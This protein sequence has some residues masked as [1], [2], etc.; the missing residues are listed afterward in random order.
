VEQIPREVRPQIDP[1][2]GSAFALEL[3]QLDAEAER[4][5]ASGPDGE[6]RALELYK[7]AV[8]FHFDAKRYDE[9]LAAIDKTLKIKPQAY[10]LATKGEILRQLGGE[11]RLNEAVAALEEAIRLEPDNG[12]AHVVYGETLRMLNRL[13]DAAAELKRAVEIDSTIG[14]WHSRLAE[15]LV[16]LNRLP[17]ALD[18]LND[19]L[20]YN[21]EN[22]AALRRR[23]DVLRAMGRTAEALV[24]FDRALQLAPNHAW[25]L[26][27]KGEALRAGGKLSDA[28]EALQQAIQ[29]EP[30]GYPWAETS[31]GY[32]R[33]NQNRDA[34]ALRWF[35]QA[36]QGDSNSAWALE[37]MVRALLQLDQIEKCL[38]TSRRLLEFDGSAAF[39]RGIIGVLM[40]QIEEYAR[41]VEALELST[42]ADAK[43]SWSHN[44]LANCYIWLAR[45]RAPTE[46]EE[47]LDK[48]IAEATVA[49]ELEPSD[50]SWRVTLAEALFKRSRTD[51]AAAE[52]R[53]AHVIGLSG[54]SIDYYAASDAGWAAYRLALL[55]P[56]ESTSFLSQAEQS[57]VDALTVKTARPDSSDAVSVKFNLA[58]VMLCSGRFALALREFNRA[59]SL[60]A[61][62]EPGLY[63]GLLGRAKAALAEAIELWPPLRQSAH[64]HKVLTDLE[65]QH[66]SPPSRAQDAEAEE[67][68]GRRHD[69]RPDSAH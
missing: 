31:L 58:L 42:R 20:R 56:S 22:V 46:A 67:G 57:F 45:S 11:D 4:L 47:L 68:S 18:S 48:A 64:A 38:A 9:A 60:A 41:G 65:T 30:G 66:N 5:H 32:V 10:A 40:F 37:G 14:D 23:G 6:V 28:A 25:A 17:E 35:E 62:S 27:G 50:V 51:A 34:E 29:L 39:A 12:W 61:A 24:D 16:M 2:R 54:E 43:A 69:I 52:F 21:P 15:V 1:V 59:A 8:Q 44:A 55:D 33:L 19:A 3:Q 36:L 13:D 53:R 26:A 7:R 49:T 63:R